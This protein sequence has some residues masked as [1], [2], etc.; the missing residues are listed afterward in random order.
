[1]RFHP[2]AEIFPLIEGAAFDELVADIK[3]HG[4][5][6]KIW[7]YEGKILDGR[8]RYLACQKANVK[9]E[10]RPYNGSNP[11]AFVVSLN[12]QRRHLTE[13]QRGYAAAKIATL[14]HGG[15]RKSDQAANLPLETQAHAAQMLN[16]SERT[17]RS[18]RKV[19]EKGSKALQ[20]A[21]ETDKVSISRAA[22]V[23]NLP[24]SEQLAAATAKP[25]PQKERFEAGVPDYVP[26]DKD[27]EAALAQA[28]KTLADAMDKV[29]ESDDR[30]PALRAQIK[31]LSSQ[32]AV[33]EQSRTHYQNQAGE[34]V[35]MLK[36]E[37]RKT[38]ALEKKL[39]KAEEDLAALKDRKVA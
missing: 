33:T 26:D 7:L 25:E 38:A 17:V 14:A 27:E 1:M 36:S 39:K 4:L 22:A 6:E 15:D 16:V 2:Y 19:L 8:N 37:Q 3:A 34:A 28:E 10:T 23:V 35:R 21:V 12:V 13:T 20:Q 32:L 11:L 29:M 9:L 18:G 30:F 5:R 31:R 24:K